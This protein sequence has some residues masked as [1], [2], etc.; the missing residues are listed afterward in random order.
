MQDIFPKHD[1]RQGAL[2]AKHKKKEQEKK[3]KIFKR[4]RI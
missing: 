2:I 4:E 3:R 1:N